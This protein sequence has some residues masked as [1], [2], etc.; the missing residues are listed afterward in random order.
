[1]IITINCDSPVKKQLGDSALQR[2]P[3]LPD[4]EVDLELWVHTYPRLH[5]NSTSSSRFFISQRQHTKMMFLPCTNI[6][7]HHPT[8][9]TPGRI[10]SA[11]P[12]RCRQHRLSRSIFRG[13]A[14]ARMIKPISGSSGS[15][16][17]R[18][19]GNYTSCTRHFLPSDEAPCFNS[20]GSQAAF[21]GQGRRL[22]S[23]FSTTYCH[24]RDSQPQKSTRLLSR[25][26]ARYAASRDIHAR[27]L[28]IRHQFC[29]PGRRGWE[30]TSGRGWLSCGSRGGMID[31]LQ[32]V[33]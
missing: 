23:V 7:F 10:K 22:F 1:M 6:K 20:I 25:G 19:T 9:A 31:S 24:Q 3:I 32:I 26:T 27:S 21:C 17:A 5:I 28:R 15:L 11:I 13:Y 30:R 4:G 18:Y 33:L 14:H 16:R 2:K 12:H 8:K 29:L